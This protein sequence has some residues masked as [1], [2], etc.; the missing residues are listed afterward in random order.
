MIAEQIVSVSIPVEN[1]QTDV[2]NLKKMW[3]NNT[4]TTEKQCNYSEL[5]HI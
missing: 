1:H 2:S 5:P 4:E 3:R